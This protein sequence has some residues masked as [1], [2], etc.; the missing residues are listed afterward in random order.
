MGDALIQSTLSLC[1]NIIV[2][3]QI[4]IDGDYCTL[5]KEI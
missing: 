1:V 5:T 4:E 2:M 3:W